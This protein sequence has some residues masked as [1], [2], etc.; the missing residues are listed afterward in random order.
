MYH[1]FSTGD[2]FFQIYGRHKFMGNTKPLRMQYEIKHIAL[3]VWMIF[4]IYIP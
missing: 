2:F 3:Y 4:I 1:V